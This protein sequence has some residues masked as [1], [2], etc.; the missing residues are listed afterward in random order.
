L[1]SVSSIRFVTPDVAIEDGVATVVADD[2]PPMQTHYSAVHVKLSGKWLLDSVRESA[3]APAASPAEHLAE[4]EWLVGEWVDEDETSTI[5]SIVHW[6][7]NRAF[8]VQSYTVFVEDQASMQGTQVIGWD[9]VQKKIRSWAFDSEGGF[10]E[11]KWEA[12]PDGWTVRSQSTL[13]DGRSGSATNFY[14][15]IDKNHFGWKSADRKLG[16]ESLPDVD[17][18][19]VARV[20][21]AI[22]LT[23]HEE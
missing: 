2:E 10:A 11:G 6:T 18:V 14:R 21:D 16:E 12:T 1:A 20:D 23:A 5:H 22:A 7:P 9:S 19:V 13:A 3:E 8:L 15:P 4:L 17:E